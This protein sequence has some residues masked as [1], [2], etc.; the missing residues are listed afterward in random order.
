MRKSSLPVSF[1][2]LLKYRDEGVLSFDSPVQRNNDQWS[3]LQKSIFIHSVLGDFI[4]PN[5]Y[6]TKE[7]FEGITKL[8]VLDGKQRLSTLISFKGSNTSLIIILFSVSYLYSN[9][10]N[11]LLNN[12]FKSNFFPSL[13]NNATLFSF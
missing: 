8:S 13:K 5:V 12:S 11:C 3:V 10:F 4:V 9:C 2:T 6:L 7:N 1:K